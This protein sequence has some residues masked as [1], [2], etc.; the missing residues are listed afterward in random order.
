[1]FVKLKSLNYLYEINEN[2]V[3]RNVKTKRIVKGYTENNGYQR[4]R[5]ENKGIGGVVR[6]SIHQL[7]AE[8]FIPNPD[9]KPFINHIDC[10]KQ[11]NCVDNLEWV[12]HSENMRHAYMNGLG[13]RGLI[14]H[15]ENTKKR[16]TNGE[17]I[18]PS[19]SDASAWLVSQSKCSNIS[20][21]I[22]GISAV[23]NGR[24]KTLGGY[25]WKTI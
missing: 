25:N 2:G 23:I 24:R 15:R 19:I 13:T 6:T 4:V 18:F 9:N 21:G 10:N 17:R 11:N 7:V 8:A 14:E 3:L 12:T 1:M 22:A 20:S 16:I 5:I